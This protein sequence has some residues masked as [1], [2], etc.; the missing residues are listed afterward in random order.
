MR[1]RIFFLSEIKSGAL[2]CGGDPLLDRSEG[3][4]FGIFDDVRVFQLDWRPH[5]VEGRGPENDPPC[6]GQA[7]QGK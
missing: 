1:N 5:V 2:F 7:G 3:V 4:V 6:P